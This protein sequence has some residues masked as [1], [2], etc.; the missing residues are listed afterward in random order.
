MT[1]SHSRI[2]LA[3]CAAVL[4]GGLAAAAAPRLEVE[5]DLVNLGEVLRGEEREVLFE[6]RNAGDA[7]LRIAI[8]PFTPGRGPLPASLANGYNDKLLVSLLSQSGTRYRFIAREALGAVIKEIDESSAREAELDDLL[9][10]LVENAKADVLV[11]A[12]L[13]R[14]SDTSAVLSYEVV[15]VLDGTILAATSFQ[16]LTLDPAEVELAARSEA[17]AKGALPDVRSAPT[18][19]PSE[20]DPAPQ[21]H[22]R[23]APPR[24][25]RRAR[26]G[27]PQPGRG[28]VARNG[29]GDRPRAVRLRH[30]G[31]PGCGRGPQLPDVHPALH[32]RPLRAGRNRCYQGRVPGHGR[33]QA[34][35]DRGS[36][37][38]RLPERRVELGGGPPGPLRPAGPEPSAPGHSKPIS[39]TI[40]AKRRVSRSSRR[41]GVVLWRKT[42]T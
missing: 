22:G 27:Q 34:P 4:A 3:V 11:V 13:R 8:R 28:G 41:K 33:R 36:N 18:P 2:A 37:G 31:G 38:P 23:P 9:T 30:A 7:P 29:A 42:W 32:R 26:P 5:R 21:D 14:T 19:V 25:R 24:R 40:A 10:A 6:L 12:K 17:R 16:R 1:T 39:R 35:P 15:K 20:P